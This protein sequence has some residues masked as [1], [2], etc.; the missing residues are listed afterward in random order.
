MCDDSP[1]RLKTAELEKL[2]ST[3]L[4]A[5]QAAGV[6]PHPVVNTTRSLARNFW[7]KAWMKQ[8]AYCESG[9]MCLA[10]GRALLRHSC[11][12]DLQ[13]ESCSIRALISAEE[14]YD[15]HLKLA[16]LDDERLSALATQCSNHVDSLLSLLE[17]KVDEALLQQLCDPENGLLPTPGDW[18]M[19]CSCPDWSEPCPHAAAAIY[20]AGCLIDTDPRLLFLLRGITPEALLSHPASTPELNPE[21]LSSTFG[22][23][24][25][26][27]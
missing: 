19:S 27:F 21:E 22:I 14:L 10:P 18:Q 23:D 2:A 24:I 20:A 25:D 5:L 6:S 17:G 8:L 3:R 11:V 1:P 15:V 13:V 26:L 16:P 12:L 7:G 9:G 4:T